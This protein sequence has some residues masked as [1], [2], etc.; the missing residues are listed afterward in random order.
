VAKPNLVPEVL[1]VTA[2]A[3]LAAIGSDGTIYVQAYSL[4]ALT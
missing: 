4:H 1:G 2:D 3:K